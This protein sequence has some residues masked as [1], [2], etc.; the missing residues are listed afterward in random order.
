VIHW[1]RSA[2]VDLVLTIPL[3]GAYM[4][5]ALGI[6]FA[7]RASRVLN[8]A[9][10]AMATLPAYVAYALAP[11]T[12]TV[13]AMAG[14]AAVGALLGAVVERGV[15][16]RLRPAGTTAQTVGTVAVLGFLVAVIAKTWGTTPL[17]AAGVFPRGSFAVGD[18]QLQWGSVGLFGVAVASAAACWWLLQRTDL[19]L[20]LRGAA[21]NPRAASLMGINPNR[22]AAIAW[23]LSGLLAGTGGVLLAA[24]T[25]L[26]PYV[27]S[28]QVLPAFVAALLGGLESVTGAMWGAAVV[29]CVI[30]LVPAVSHGFGHQPGAPQLVLGFGTLVVM[31]VRGSAQAQQVSTDA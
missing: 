9:H 30:G 22:A 16:R 8:L 13:V 2:G 3:I 29:G 26:H 25:N 23:S 28:L 31:M 15:V 24:A 21:A 27:L 6:V 4:M 11:R 1:L 19:G 7:Y 17:R 5:F 10:G 20:A 12:G 14:A 18:A